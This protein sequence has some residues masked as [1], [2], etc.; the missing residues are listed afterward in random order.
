MKLLT[1][2][3]LIGAAIGLFFVFISP[4]FKTA[5]DVH[6]QTQEYDMALSRA[7]LVGAKR[8]QLLA[9]KNSFNP[10]D[11]KRL[12]KLLP[13]SIDPIRLIIDMDSLANK[14]GSNISSIKV[15]DETPKAAAPA[16]VGATAVAGPQL[17][18]TLISFSVTMTYER[19]QKYLS[20]VEHSLRILDVASISFSPI[21]TSNDYA[22][23]VA[24]R[25]YYLKP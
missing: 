2:F 13:D 19:F 23:S 24:L 10:E 22:F 16:A 20:D 6:A 17:G 15:T 14:S 1:P 3:L 8:D 12:Q 18:S 21:D 7:Q 11:I 9:K 25:T 4:E 5:N